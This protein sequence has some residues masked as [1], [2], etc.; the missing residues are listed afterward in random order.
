MDL[1]ES[2]ERAMI[3]PSSGWDF[4]RLSN[5]KEVSHEFLKKV[6]VLLQ[7]LPVSDAKK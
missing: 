3:M 2:H 7:S 5:M 1:L 6:R 4:S